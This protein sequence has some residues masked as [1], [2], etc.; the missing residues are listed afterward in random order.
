M[1]KCDKLQSKVT[2]NP[3]KRTKPNVD[4]IRTSKYMLKV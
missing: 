1:N 3:D 2:A 4:L